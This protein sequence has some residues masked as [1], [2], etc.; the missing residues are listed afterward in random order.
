[1]KMVAI[2]A[3]MDGMIVAENVV[4]GGQTVI[5]RGSMVNPPLRQKLVA[6][7]LKGINIMEPGDAPQTYYEKIRMSQEFNTFVNNYSGNLRAYKAAVDSF[8]LNKVPFRLNDLKQIANYLV[9]DSMMGTTLF[10]YLYLHVPTQ[11]ELTYAHGLNVAL[12]CRI[13]ARWLKM[14]PEE[15]DTLVLCGFLYDIGKFMIPNEIL[16]KPEKLNKMEFDLVKTHAYH[17]YHLLKNY[18]KNVNE[19]VLNATLQHHESMDGSGYPQGL[20]ANDIDNYAKIMSILDVYEALTSARPYRHP[21]CPYAVVEIMMQDGYQR[22][23]AGYLMLFLNKIVDEL[24][25]NRVRLS[26]GTEGEVVMN[27]K[28]YLSRPIVSC[29]GRVVDLS[30][31]RNLSIVEI[32]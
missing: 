27:N 22:Y 1:M 7:G 9:T 29:Q 32:V 28:N 16:W 10:A 8:I 31:E 3:L 25:G 24:I 17:G 11:E 5:N 23:D 12:I 15:A 2:G 4:V 18:S 20:V 30:K 26:D 13:F 6:M 14:T 21:K 19:H